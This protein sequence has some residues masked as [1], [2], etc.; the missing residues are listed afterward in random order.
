MIQSI[1][2]FVILLVILLA[3]WYLVSFIRLFVVYLFI[4]LFV[5]FNYRQA[6]GAVCINSAA[7]IACAVCRVISAKGWAGLGESC[8]VLCA[9]RYCVAVA[10]SKV[11]LGDVTSSAYKVPWRCAV[12]AARDAMDRRGSREELSK[13]GGVCFAWNIMWEQGWRGARV[14][15]GSLCDWLTDWL[16]DWLDL[17]LTNLISDSCYFTVKM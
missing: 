4:S 15:Y 3:I 13:R 9:V 14:V 12:T 5:C 2:L 6:T 10:D 7:D 11:I 1:V 16:T 17:M 8:V